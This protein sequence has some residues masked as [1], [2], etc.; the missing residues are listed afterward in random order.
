MLVSW[1][2]AAAAARR[3]LRARRPAARPPALSVP[4]AATEETTFFVTAPNGRQK[5]FVLQTFTSGPD[6]GLPRRT[7]VVQGCTGRG[8]LD[9]EVVWRSYDFWTWQPCP[10]LLRG[11]TAIRFQ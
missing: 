11:Y 6:L 9:Y 4:V 2:T 5:E 3:R 1:P 8:P 10:G 7:W